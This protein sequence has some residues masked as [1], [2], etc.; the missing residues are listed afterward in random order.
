MTDKYGALVGASDRTSAYDQSGE[1]WW[2]AAYNNGQ[3]AVFIGQPDYDESS[4]ATT[5]IIAMPLY[6]HGNHEV[7]GVLRSTY[8]LK[9]LTDLMATVHIGKTGDTDLLL[10]TE[11]ILKADGAPSRWIWRTGE[12]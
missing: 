10:P 9:S 4:K 11:A 8:R 5:V 7:I 3:G 6:G 2:Q 1:Q 12:R